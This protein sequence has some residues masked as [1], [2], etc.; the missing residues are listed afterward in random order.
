M[1]CC[2]CCCCQL[3]PGPSLKKEVISKR[4]HHHRVHTSARQAVKHATPQSILSIARQFEWLRVFGS[5]SASGVCLFRCS[6][7]KHVPGMYQP[8]INFPSRTRHVNHPFACFGNSSISHTRLTC[9]L[10]QGAFTPTSDNGGVYF[11][12]GAFFACL[13]IG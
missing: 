2:C 11:V 13:V 7:A 5:L 6:C 12:R 9:Q 8:T 10:G 1:Y 4:A 3:W